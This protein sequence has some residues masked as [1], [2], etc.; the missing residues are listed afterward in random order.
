[1]LCGSLI[2]CLDVVCEAQLVEGFDDVVAS[3]GLLCFLLRNL[4]CLGRYQCDEL[5]AAL[6]EK[7]PSLFGKGY[8]ILWREDLCDNLLDGG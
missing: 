1:M 7:V 8:S 6:N 3:N 5:N 2:D 4:V